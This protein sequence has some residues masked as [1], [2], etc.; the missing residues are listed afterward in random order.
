MLCVRMY[1]AEHRAD[2]VLVEAAYDGCRHMLD[3]AATYQRS[4]RQMV[5]KLNSPVINKI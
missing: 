5:P 3:L 4:A 2:G 1:V